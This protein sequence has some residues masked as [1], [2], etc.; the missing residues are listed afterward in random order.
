LLLGISSVQRV[1]TWSGVGRTDIV[2]TAPPAGATLTM[3]ERAVGVDVGVPGQGL[4]YDLNLRRLQADEGGQAYTARAAAQVH[5][6]KPLILWAVDT[7][8]EEVGPGPIAW[9]ENKVFGAKD[10]VKRTAFALM[11]ADAT[12]QLKDS[13]AAG[14]LPAFDRTAVE[15]DTRIWPPAPIPSLWDRPMPGEG[16][17]KPSTPAFLKRLPCASKDESRAPPY[18]YETFIRPDTKRPYA[19]L[20]L[21]AMDMRQLELG[22]QAGYEDP[23]PLTGPPGEGRLPDEPQV[24]ARVVGTFNGAFK[25]THGEYGMMVHRRVLLPPMPGA[26]TVIVDRNGR[27]GLGSWPQTRQVPEDV[28]SFRQ[29]LD[30][31]VE[32]GVANPT[33]RYVWGWQIEGTSVM[34]QRTALCVTSAGHVYYAWAEEIDG[35][36]LGKALR[37]AGC[38]YGIHLDMNPGH[39]GFVYTD[40]VDAKA[41][42]YNLKLAHPKMTIVP[43]KYVRW[44]AKDFFY[45]ML[46]DD[47]P[48]GPAG[49][50]WQVDSGD[51]PPPTWFPGIHMGKLT[52]GGLEITLLSFA[53]NRFQW[54]VRAGSREPALLD[55]PPMKLELTSQEARR[56]LAAVGLGHTTLAAGYGLAF[57]GKASLPIRQGYATVVVGKGRSLEVLAP[58]KTPD[59][60]PGTEAVQLPVLADGDRRTEEA[61]EPGALRQRGALCVLP[62]GRVLVALARHDSSSPLAT[63]LLRAGCRRIVALDR[64]SHHPAFVHRAGTDTPPIVDY[65]TSVLFALA[66]PMATSA[67]RWKPDGSRRSIRPTGYDVS[68]RKPAA[69]A[70][71]DPRPRE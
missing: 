24:L 9:L 39:C 26:A 62:S 67:F 23:E 17:W 21:V 57:D 65:E 8:R 55:A 43:D 6:P 71:A 64:G 56:A 36:T 34:T 19:K 42:Q 48:A 46:R 4:V 32:D 38:V 3:D 49:V 27:T 5:P 37:Q 60:G 2:F 50:T 40:V 10:T 31:L 54:R 35:P 69:L 53:A 33:G 63:A 59:L 25:T 61:H 47:M 20:L 1:G 22:M 45:V 7:A 29:N 12:Y 58:G 41:N 18:F 15:G 11:A 66:A 44:S 51:Q 13:V 52:L 68:V 16:E 70:G 30:P 14:R 28:D